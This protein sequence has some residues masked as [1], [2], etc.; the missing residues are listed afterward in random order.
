MEHHILAFTKIKRLKRELEY[1]K[2][3]YTIEDKSSFKNEKPK[4]YKELYS[5]YYW[6]Y[7]YKYNTN[8]L[9][10]TSILKYCDHVLNSSFKSCVTPVN[11]H[12]ASKNVLDVQIIM[13]LSEDDNFYISEREWYVVGIGKETAE[14]YN[15]LN[16]IKTSQMFID[17]IKN[18]PMTFDLLN[19]TTDSDSNIDIMQFKELLAL[20]G[21][22]L[23]SIDDLEPYI[24]S[25][26]IELD[27]TINYALKQMQLRNCFDFL[28]SEYDIRLLL[29]KELDYY[30]QWDKI[31]EKPYISYVPPTDEWLY[32][33]NISLMVVGSL[34]HYQKITENMTQNTKMSLYDW[35][36]FYSIT[37]LPPSFIDFV[38]TVIKYFFIDNK[39]NLKKIQIEFAT[40]GENINLNQI[41][42]FFISK[43]NLTELIDY[44]TKITKEEFVHF[45]YLQKELYENA[46]FQLR[47]LKEFYN[48]LESNFNKND[49]LFSKITK[50]KDIFKKNTNSQTEISSDGYFNGVCTT[51]K[52]MQD[53]IDFFKKNNLLKINA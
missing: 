24:L 8:F 53:C 42:D 19:T 5:E 16:E 28:D 50:L 1:I 39:A 44:H 20:L 30:F 45:L 40:K 6:K 21:I 7:F 23:S 12:G 49:S 26:F 41:K 52:K 43:K 48:L 37:I 17:Y 4:Y 31:T 35:Q 29:N 34:R 38:S 2:K 3:Y 22:N 36:K 14:I 11:N 47:D 27:L 10:N 46:D 18:L 13:S 32:F 33:Q 15:L 51:L 9:N 25:R